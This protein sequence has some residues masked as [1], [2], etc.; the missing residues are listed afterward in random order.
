MKKEN[1]KSDE[2]WEILLSNPVADEMSRNELREALDDASRMWLAHDGLWFQAVERAHGMQAAVNADRE[3]W[4]E[5][6]K[7]EAR[8]ILKRMGVEEGKG[9][10]DELAIAL[11]HRLYAN[12]NTL[13]IERRGNVLRMTMVDCRV[14]SA[15]RRKEM[16]L[17]PCKSVGIVEY[18]EFAKII[19]PQFQTS[20]GFCPPDPLGE[21]GYCQ[22]IFTL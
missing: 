14:Q 9:G 22:W 8:R 21:E 3:T 13:K 4:S 12:I 10:I 16:E 5:F 11:R 2:N 19:N 20:C 17:F 7:I 6:T 18:S 1:E 15:R